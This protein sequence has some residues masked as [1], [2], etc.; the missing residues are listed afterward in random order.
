[1][2][3]NKEYCYDCKKEIEI[4]GKEIKNGVLLTYDDDGEKISVFKCNECFKKS[5]ALTNFK[6]C[7]IYSRVVGYI[8][9][10]KQ[11]HVGKRQEYKDRKEYKQP[12][13]DK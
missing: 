11:W 9:P 1:M 6:E 4:K 8:R 3:T 2:K 10:V 5:S 7:E 12:Q 13:G